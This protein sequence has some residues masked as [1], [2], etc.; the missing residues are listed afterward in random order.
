MR[1]KEEKRISSSAPL[2]TGMI[3]ACAGLC[4][5]WGTPAFGQDRPRLERVDVAIY[6]APVRVAPAV[7]A[8]GEIERLGSWMDYRPGSGIRGSADCRVFDCFGDSDSDGFMDDTGGCGLSTSRWSFGTAYCNG[9]AT[10]DMSGVPRNAEY[11]RADF[12]WRW[13]CE[14]FGEEQCVIGIF[15]Q[16]SSPEPGDDPGC[17]QDSFDYEGWLIDFGVRSCNAGGY[18]YTNVDLSDFGG[19]TG[20]TDGDGSYAIA[21][22]TDSGN[23]LAT[24]AQP[25]LWG[26]GNNE[27]GPLDGPGAQGP[28]QLDDDN[29]LDGEHQIFD[30]CHTYSYDV[31][32]DPLGAM[33]QF[34]GENCESSCEYPDCNGDRAVDTRDVVCFLRLWAGDHRAADCTGDGVVNSQD[35]IC[36]LEEW[37]RCY[38]P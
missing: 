35:L 21:F 1:R 4:C 20:V 13:T 36:F 12:A 8:A 23:A 10:N 29:P 24:C 2:G 5:W 27:G 11:G 37:S 17:G 26:A 18:Y 22:L 38:I 6:A 7:L 28:Y 16:E 3:A 9:L 31:C 19:W 15:T 34:W 32:P 25:M 30:E 33:L 14:G